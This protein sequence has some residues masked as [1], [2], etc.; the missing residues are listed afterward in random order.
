MKSTTRL[1]RA[2]LLF[3]GIVVALG[4][5]PSAECAADV[6]PWKIRA[7]TS[8]VDNGAVLE[9]KLVYVEGNGQPGVQRWPQAAVLYFEPLT[10]PG[11][12]RVSLRARTEKLGASTLTLQAWVDKK[13][14]GLVFP[15]GHGPI[16]VPVASVGMS[17][18]VFDEP[19]KWQTLSL[20]F[21]VE[22]DKPTHVGLMY[23]GA[24]PDWV[25]KGLG[26]KTSEAGAVQVEKSS[27]ELQKVDLPVS[28]SW[29]RPVKLRYKHSEFGSLEIRLTNATEQAQMV[30][31]R[32]VVITDTDSRM[33]GESKRFTV[34]A[35][36][37]ISGRVAF[38]V[39]AEDGG[40]QAT[41]ELISGGKVIDQR[42]DVFCVTDS[43]FR[44]MIQGDGVMR[45]PYLLSGSHHLGLKGFQKTVMDQWD[46]YVRDATLAM[47]S[48]RRAY[49][50]YYEYFAWAREDATVMTEDSDEPYL[51][52]QTFYPISRKQILLLNGLMR[53]HGIAP[54]AYLNSIPFGWP[55]FEVIRRRPLWFRTDPKT[56]WASTFFNTAVLEKYQNGVAVSGSVY[57]AIEVNFDTPSAIDGKTYLDYHLDQLLASVK[58]YGW[59]AYRYDAAPLPTEH[60][61][62]FKAALAELDP[63]VGIGNNQGTNCLGN[64]PS[65]A[66]RIYCRDGSLMME[67]IVVM[68]FHN[69]ADERRRWVNYIASLR[70]SSHLTRSHG[71]HF[72]YINVAGN[73]YSTTIGYALGGHPWGL[74]KSPFGDCERFMV[75]Y[76]SY[77][78]DLRTQMLPNPD[79]TLSVASERPLW[80]KPLASQRVLDPKHRQIVVPLFNPPAE[81]EV[82]GTTSVG[83]ADGVRVS[84]AP[85]ANETVT[86]WLLAPEPVPSRTT[87]PTKALPD[88]SLQVEVPRFWGWTN[89]VFDCR[90]Q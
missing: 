30:E 69:P 66:W 29:A 18:Y 76:G 65:D 48:R 13:D 60:F 89:V 14:G 86:A 80:W 51:S 12:Y 53:Q 9:N 3:A 39:P 35:S 7:G 72:T 87:L 16:P 67:E 59:E 57:P 21:D 41:G 52:G 45:L 8:E 27:I 84:F 34:P 11:R 54:V 75:Q 4:L 10:Q 47:E 23:G 68:A 5:W 22:R 28:I 62:R 81:E 20:E 40:Y 82:V 63:P 73:W 37:T 85:K 24:W 36:A 44:C 58:L 55:G 77:F 25:H 64:Q 50:T 83:P 6:R 42:G 74:Y 71:G 79:E 32:P 78:W 70:E 88:G 43:P 15:T 90:S 26:D 33:P 38:D 2:G 49:S 31:V 56:R 19:G 17:G 46:R 1:V 61:P